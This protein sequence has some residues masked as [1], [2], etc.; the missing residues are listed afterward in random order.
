MV[1]GP[2][3]DDLQ[4]VGVQLADDNIPGVLVGGVD[5][6]QASLVHHQ[7][8]VGVASPGV[9]VRIVEAGVVELPGLADRRRTEVEL[10][11]DVALELVKV[12]G[13]VVYHLTCSRPW[14]GQPVGREVV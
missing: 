11:D 4:R 3:L 12:D 2:A 14:V 10:D 8:D 5:G 6:P 13:A 7:V 1:G 9:V